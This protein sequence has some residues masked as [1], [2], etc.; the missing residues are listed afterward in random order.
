VCRTPRASSSSTKPGQTT[1]DGIE[2][3][4]SPFAR[5]LFEGLEKSPDLYFHQLLQLHVA[6]AVIEATGRAGFTQV[7]ETLTRGVAPDACLEGAGCA[8][9]ERAGALQAELERLRTE[10]GRD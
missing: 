6:K 2:G 5:A 3:E 10:R 9:D 8:A 4:H 7:P 1:L